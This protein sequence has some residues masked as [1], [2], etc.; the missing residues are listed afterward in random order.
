MDKFQRLFR[1]QMEEKLGV[2]SSAE[3]VPEFEIYRLA[4]SIRGTAGTIGLQD[5][6]EA[7]DQLIKGLIDDSVREWPTSEL[8]SYLQPLFSLLADPE[9][10]AA[11]PATPAD[12]EEEY[13]ENINRTAVPAA[14][15]GEPIKQNLIVVVDDDAALLRVL[16]EA[17]EEYGWMVMATPL[18]VK[19][20]EWC[21]D[22]EPDCVVLDIV[23]EQSSGF[24]L[25]DSLRSR[26]EERLIP[27]ILMSARNDKQT[28]M[29]SY[30]SGADDFIA[31]PFDLEEFAARIGR[32]LSRRRRLTSA[33]MRDELTGAYNSI[34]FR[35]EL[36]RWRSAALPE[37]QPL[38][39]ALLD[40][41]H[42]RKANGEGNYD[43]GDRLLREFS[44]FVQSRLRD[45]DIWAR[46]R[47]DRFYLLQPGITETEA[48]SFAN[49]LLEDFVSPQPLPEHSA[50]PGVTF[51][52]GLTSLSAEL[53]SEQILEQVGL[54]AA[55]SKAAGGGICTVY[56]EHQPDVVVQEQP[57]RLA[58][59]DDDDLIR[60]LL[61]K[62][63]S[64]L[65]RNYN[66]EI[67]KFKDGE[68][69]FSNPWHAMGGR[70]LVVLDRMMPRMN[71]MEVLRKLRSGAGRGDYTVLMLTG[72]N[73]EREIA[74]AIQAGTD[75]Y[76]TKPF[77]L[78]ELEARVVRLLRGMIR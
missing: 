20:L 48:E 22:L 67:G 25:L 55:A 38:S 2:L 42:F 49:R 4:H 34:F 70:Y 28:R 14:A 5:W 72:V 10:A 36:E 76:L 46:E 71:G 63:L 12:P 64:D 45:Q 62:Q 43:E 59:V 9:S 41:D 61:A 50:L 51:S 65:S 17:L 21:Y 39:L 57:L 35:Q 23:L 15:S 16:K 54:A 7:A 8:K 18:P 11:T 53:P 60:N 74:E 58:I 6:S 75:D 32:Q 3:H 30:A 26:C 13:S 52:V 78:I 44:S 66:I 19:A 56:R 1:Q 31:K 33:L 47:A 37:G 77:S 29:K 27:T 69:F 73:E 24:E 40:I 68:D